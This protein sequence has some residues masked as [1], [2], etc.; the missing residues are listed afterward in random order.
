MRGL[1]CPSMLLHRLACALTVIKMPSNCCVSEQSPRPI[2]LEVY[3]A[4]NR[5]VSDQG[6]AESLALNGIN[7]PL[8]L[9]SCLVNFLDRSL[10][11]CYPLRII[12]SGARFT[13]HSL[14]F[15]T[16]MHTY[17]CQQCSFLY[18]VSEMKV[19]SARLGGTNSW[20]WSKTNPGW[21]DCNPAV[22]TTNSSMDPP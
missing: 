20:S 18:P 10:R 12:I 21:F 5:F 8:S 19:N 22:S 15:A 13:L 16:N 11:R 17:S 3:C 7:K 14:L 1:V 2:I 9:R 6:K 4:R